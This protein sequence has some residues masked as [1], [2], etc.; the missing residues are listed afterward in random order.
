MILRVEKLP[1]WI[2]VQIFAHFWKIRFCSFLENKILLKIGIGQK[3]YFSE[4]MISS[5]K[6]LEISPVFVAASPFVDF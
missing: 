1:F 2:K 4:T 6:A 5:G 3:H